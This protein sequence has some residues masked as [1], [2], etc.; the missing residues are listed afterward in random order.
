LT[1]VPVADEWEA[2]GLRRSPPLSARRLPPE[3]PQILV[4]HVD[5]GERNLAEPF[6]G[7]TTDG[8][9][10]P[11]LFP[12]TS[13][14]LSTTP[15]VDAAQAFL[16]S[17]D[18]DQRE[19]VS[20]PIDADEWRQWSNVHIYLVRH[21][22]LLDDLDVGQRAAALDLVRASLSAR[23][24]D[25][26]SRVMRFNQLLADLT[27]S[28]EEYGEWLFFI[29]VFGTPSDDQPFGWQLDGHHLNLHCVVV[30][31]QVVLTPALLGTE[32]TRVTSGPYA[33]LRMWEAEEHNGL[34]MVRSL[35]D[36][37][38]ATAILYPS[39]LKP[40]LPPERSVP[41]DGQMM[42]CAFRDNRRLEYEGL[43][44]DAMSD[45]QR[46]LLRELIGTYVGRIRDGHAELEL[47]R[48]A[49]HFEETHF[50]WMGGTDDSSPF[51]YKVQSPVILIEFDHEPGVVFANDDPTRHHVHTVVR[52]PNGNDYG[53][54]LLRQHYERSDHHRPG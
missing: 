43:R 33:G 9:V 53:K 54:D 3:L 25:D 17:L 28:R 42:A 21:G 5:V 1:T 26:V 30:G 41:I 47:D 8:T 22:L 4:D 6:V 31:D 12:L 39:I 52:T 34:A 38:A 11:G 27:D 51:Y 50:C 46:R 44:A 7:I 45:G 24:F 2:L 23:G 14:G 37:Q 20:F 10:R 29:S 15:I 19:K 48:V 32:P 18:A 16:A 40:D 36:E 49:R 35:S 13:T